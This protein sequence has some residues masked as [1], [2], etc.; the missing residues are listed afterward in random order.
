MGTEWGRRC[1][2]N[3]SWLQLTI[4]KAE[5]LLAAGKR[6]V[7]EDGRFANEAASAT[8]SE[9]DNMNGAREDWRIDGWGGISGDH[10]SEAQ[11]FS[12]DVRWINRAILR[13]WN[14]R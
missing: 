1:F 12:A 3:D 2:F 7:I 10:A 13:T 14:P 5:A 4:A 9:L 11:E 6:V 8:G